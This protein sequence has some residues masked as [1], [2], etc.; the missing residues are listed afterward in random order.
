MYDPGG[1]THT[2]AEQ[3]G[4]KHVFTPWNLVYS[5]GVEFNK[6]YSACRG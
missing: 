6:K 2:T 1:S 4:M 3:A 5:I